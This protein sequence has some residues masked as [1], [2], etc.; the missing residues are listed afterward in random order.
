[1]NLIDW[2]GSLGVFLI[3]LAYFLNVMGKISNKSLIFILMNIIGALMACLA[4]ILLNYVPF[5]ILE[6]AWAVVSIISLKNIYSL[7]YK[8]HDKN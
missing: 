1:M 7:K 4:S 5:I 2:V 6:G 8:C 3:L